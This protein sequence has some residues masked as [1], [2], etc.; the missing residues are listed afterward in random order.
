M[1]AGW[2]ELT[3]TICQRPDCEHAAITGHT[4]LHEGV[5]LPMIIPAGGTPDQAQPLDMG[6]FDPQ[7]GYHWSTHDPGK[8]RYPPPEDLLYCPNFG[9]KGPSRG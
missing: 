6:T 7:C 1:S 9:R 3:L 2:P 8:L 4:H 5:M